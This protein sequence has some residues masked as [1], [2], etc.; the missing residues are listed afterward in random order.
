MRL[1]LLYKALGFLFLGLAFIGVFL[2]VLPTVPFILVAAYYFSKSSPRMYQYLREHKW[3]GKTIVQW[4][5]EKC[6]PCFYKK[7]AQGT[8]LFSASLSLLFIIKPA[9]LKLIALALF[10][11]GFFYVTR[12]PCCEKL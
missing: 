8:I 12:I 5:E 4:E 11:Y 10:A 6:I 9:F 3:F 7:V 2:P 1:R